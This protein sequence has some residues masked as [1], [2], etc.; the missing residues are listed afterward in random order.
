MI[1]RLLIVDD[2]AAT[3]KGL[4]CFFDWESIDCTVAATAC[5]GAEAIEIIKTTPVDIVITDIKMPVIDGLELARYIYENRPQIAVI[6][7]TGY[8]EFEYAR[9]AIRYNVSSFLLKPTPKEEIVNAVKE[10]QQKIIVSKRHDSI[11][12]SELAFLKDQFLQELTYGGAGPDTDKRLAEFQIALDRYYIAAFRLDSP[13]AELNQLKELIIRQKSNSF[14]F[15]YNN[16]I[17]SVYFYEDLAPVL[18]NCQE[19]IRIPEHLYSMKVFVGVSGLHHGPAEFST[20]TFEAIHTLSLTFYSPS[21][22][23]VFDQAGDRSDNILSA[24]DTLS[25]YELEND[26][27][28]RDF[29]SALLVA[30]ALFLKLKSNFVNE[31]DAKNICS[32]IYY[33]TFRVLAKSGRALPPEDFLTSIGR[34]A[35]IFQLEDIIKRLLAFTRE[36]L[37]SS[38]REYS[39]Y[40]QEAITYIREHPAENLTLD[41][42]ARHTHMNSSYLSRIFKKE[43]GCSVTEYIT[44][45]RME[46][47]KELLETT[48]LLTYEIAEKIGINEPSYFS[49]LFKKFAGLTPTEYRS[50]FR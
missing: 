22:I 49:M 21:S 38:E 43:C 12:K 30:N 10:A 44:T 37:T 8:A 5:D 23:A 6:L 20:A 26:I 7:L 2:E 27:R 15:R 29:Q 33:L 40:V 24:E 46:K 16:L 18:E 14:C 11:A 4:S 48:N 35:D 39:Q 32:H 19:I 45:I 34:A 25:L 42:I 13:P 9:T 17:L 3:R 50:R 41:D 28:Q 31:N 1:F 36:E 47:A